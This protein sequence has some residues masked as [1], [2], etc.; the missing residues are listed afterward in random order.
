MG[1]LL[2]CSIFTLWGAEEV[3]APL[4]HEEEIGKISPLA[5]FGAGCY[6]GTEKYFAG[7]FSKFYSGRIIDGQVGFIGPL[8]APKSPS[9]E[10]VCTGETDHVEAYKV[11]YD[12]GAEVYENLIRFFFQ[13]HDPT[14]LNKASGRIN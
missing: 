3:E 12:G 14:T 8:T 1:N 2:S 5:C 4:R 10:E 6:W 7:E 13:F 11:E 9:Y